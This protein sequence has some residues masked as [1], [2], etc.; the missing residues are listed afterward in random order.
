MQSSLEDE[1]HAVALKNLGRVLLWAG[2]HEE[3]ERL[4]EDGETHFQKATLIQ[5]AGDN[6]AALVHYREAAR[7][8]PLN[9]AIHQAYGVLLSELGRKAEA[10]VELESAIRLDRTRAGVYYDLGIVLEDLGQA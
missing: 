10:L 2:K 1:A 9:P 6:K 3:A 5:R 7:L 8:A 4:S